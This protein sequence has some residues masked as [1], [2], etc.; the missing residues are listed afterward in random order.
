MSAN[1]K[2]KYDLKIIGRNA[3]GYPE[4]RLPDRDHIRLVRISKARRRS[5]IVL[6]WITVPLETAPEYF[7]LSYAWGAV[8]EHGLLQYPAL[9]IS[10]NLL[11]ALPHLAERP[12]RLWWIDALC[13]NQDDKEEKSHQVKFMK[14]IYGRASQVRVWLG[15]DVEDSLPAMA[16]ICRIRNLMLEGHIEYLSDESPQVPCIPETLQRLGLPQMEH[17]S[18]TSL[19]KLV[20][21]SY[22]SRIWI[23]QEILVAKNSVM[24]MCG[25][26]TITWNSL[27]CVIVW[28]LAVRWMRE[29]GSFPDLPEQLRADIDIGLRTIENIEY[30]A[31][32]PREIKEVLY[33]SRSLQSTDPRDKIIAVLGLASTNDQVFSVI[34][35]NYEQSVP[36]FYRDVTGTIITKTLSLELLGLVEDHSQRKVETLPS[37]VPDYSVGIARHFLFYE[38]VC[39]NTPV[40]VEWRQGCNILRV[41]GRPLDEVLSVGECLILPKYYSGLY[42]MLLSWF[43]LAAHSFGVSDLLWIQDLSRPGCPI[44]EGLEQFWRAIIQNRSD[45]PYCRYPAPKIW[46]EHFGA[47]IRHALQVEDGLEESPVVATSEAP[48]PGP[49]GDSE[50]FTDH[51]SYIANKTRFFITKEGRMGLGPMSLQPGDRITIL[52]GARYIYCIRPK[53]RQY[54][55]VGH[56]WV[57]GLMDGEGLDGEDGGF[58]EMELI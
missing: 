34:D 32:S 16:L 48:A 33:F 36:E 4:P 10:E 43:R 6:K 54:Q 47:A 37:W 12:P 46:R 38:N 41:R 49:I 50:V 42:K 14:T 5:R 58:E 29:I 24:I 57:Y 9:K 52:S 22:F 40:V 2:H 51:L 35:T 21:R 23:L 26:Y 39:G 20:G 13:I 53:V 7:A 55:L 44:D 17:S 18:W 15:E 1:R 8:P 27:E 28:L 30:L 45:F 56:A 31:G 25:R 3:F 19:L 11:N